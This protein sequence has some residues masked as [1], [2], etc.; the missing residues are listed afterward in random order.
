MKRHFRTFAAGLLGMSLALS[1]PGVQV[2]A[3]ND[4]PTQNPSL[5]GFTAGS[6][7]G[8]TDMIEKTGLQQLDYTDENGVTLS[9]WLYVPKNAD[10][11]VDE[12]LPLV[13]HMHG[14]SDGGKTR[15]V[16]NRHYG[17][18]YA[19]LA[20]R[21]NPD[22]KAII[23]MPQTPQT[24]VSGTYL[25]DG[26]EAD[27]WV[28]LPALTVNGNYW[29]RSNWDMSDR[30]RSDNLNAA[31][32]L[33][34]S[35][36]STYHTDADRTYLSG[37]SMGGCA[38]WDLLLRD[39][40]HLFAAAMPMCGIGDPALAQ[41]AADVPIHMYHCTNDPTITSTAGRVMYKALAKYGSTTYTE[42]D[43][44]S[45][46]V[47]NYAWSKTLD[48]DGNGKSN[49]EDAIEWMF[50]Q[51]RNGT[52][53]HSI[54][55]APLKE[56]VEKAK[57]VSEA[58]YDPD[59]LARIESAAAA[60][61][62]LLD[63]TEAAADEVRSQTEEISVL[64]SRRS[65]NLCFEQGVYPTQTWADSHAWLAVDGNTSTFWD[66]NSNTLSPELDIRLDHPV[67]LDSI[68]VTTRINASKYYKYEIYGSLDRENWE[69]IGE[70]TNT[71]AS[72][73]AGD[74]YTFDG[75]KL[76]SWIRIKGVESNVNNSF[77]LAEMEAL[78]SHEFLD[79]EE[80]M[81][82]LEGL[83]AGE[84]LPESLAEQM[85]AILEDFDALK[86]STSTTREE[87]LALMDTAVNLV[88]TARTLPD[89][90][91][92][93]TALDKSKM[94]KM[95]AYADGE[96]KTQLSTEMQAAGAL[97]LD[98]CNQSQAIV[99][100]KAADLNSA[101]LAMRLRPDGALLDTLAD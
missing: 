1:S 66:G 7:Q 10:G 4:A 79:L 42:Y 96:Q 51:S 56:V 23:L 11:S 21:D 65:A 70:K 41:N 34:K 37:E 95:D 71:S 8:T 80:C 33:I 35:V 13:V 15:T 82:E 74:V 101:L 16:V 48:D 53:D 64:L 18:G 81:T 36:Q 55:K 2:Y 72:T 68:H 25:K 86:D 31:Y 17:L 100:Q 20:D 57:S 94:L 46:F 84:N 5:Y 3:A 49:L 28:N 60:G 73:D 30:A 67:L 24:T 6:D 97:I 75:S 50:N 99:N 89:L 63:S 54:D 38:T 43:S 9:Y 12:D 88:E 61:Q 40:E 32:N 76:V 92:L 62:Q 78:G 87:V 44:G 69:K 47:W 58:D 52:L 14:Y 77:H 93:K 98:P 39:D 90:S 83:L 29:K 19:L 59:T 85:N 45:H 27:R 26:N 22:H 91:L